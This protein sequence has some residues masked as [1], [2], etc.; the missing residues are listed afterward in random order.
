MSIYTGG[1]LQWTQTTQTQAADAQLRLASQRL[2]TVHLTAVT[3]VVGGYGLGKSTLVANKVTQYYAKVGRRVLSLQLQAAPKPNEMTVLLLRQ[4]G[5][6]ADVPGYLLRE[7]L[8]DALADERS[9]IVIDEAHHMTIDP[10]RTC[11]VLIDSLPATDWILVGTTQL[12]GQLDKVP[13]LRDRVSFPITIKP[14]T[15]DEI[16]RTMPAAHPL[17]ADAPR[18]LLAQVDAEFAQGRWRPWRDFTAAAVQIS[19]L[20]HDTTLTAQVT[21]AAI[22]ACGGKRLPPVAPTTKRRKRSAA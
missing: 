6:N 8:A 17:L 9:V 19:Q 1:P 4:L 21:D 3:S 22:T 20:T 13:E 12:P 16:L 11:K 18:E 15:L 2:E 7:L 10:L 14:L 5:V